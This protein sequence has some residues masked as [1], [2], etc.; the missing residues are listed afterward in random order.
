MKND[1]RNLL[2]YCVD[3]PFEERNVDYPA[4]ALSH[5]LL[6]SLAAT[7]GLRS[8]LDDRINEILAKHD[9]FKDFEDDLEFLHEELHDD[10]QKAL[11]SVSLGQ[12]CETYA[13]EWGPRLVAPDKKEKP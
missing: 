10:L 4:R 6:V 1:I 2:N 11:R 5:Q 9:N 12:E 8:V 13:M 7:T 3:V